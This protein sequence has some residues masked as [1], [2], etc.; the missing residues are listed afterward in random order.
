MSASES[1]Y[2]F[3]R[4]TEQSFQEGSSLSS[5]FQIRSSELF[6]IMVTIPLIEPSKPPLF[7]YYYHYLFPLFSDYFITF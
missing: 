5:K 2:V 7:S 1:D 6:N 3:V 4:V